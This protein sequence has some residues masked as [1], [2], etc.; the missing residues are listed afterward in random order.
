MSEEAY[1]EFAL[2][3]PSGGWELV[4]GRLR[5]R[6]AMTVAHGGV[7]A[8]LFGM[9]H[10]Q[11]D[12]AEYRLRSQHARLR[13]S[14][15]TYYVP[16]IAVIP[17]AMEQALATNALD[18]YPDPLPLVIE[19]WSPSTGTFDLNEKIPGYK[20]RGDVEI[21]RIHPYEQTLT[22]WRRQPDG[23]YAESVYC[24][25]IAR[26]Q[27]MPHVAIDLDELFAP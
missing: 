18:A 25:G 6:T 5:E 4:H 9:L 10:E 22:T 7:M 26:P 2:A 15:D 14:A 13:V 23:D 27:P 16:D 12:R 8:Y 17:T 3:D 24:G 20:P 11:L 19:V 21:W 1:R